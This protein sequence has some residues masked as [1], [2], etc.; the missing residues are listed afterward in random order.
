MP[1][2]Q[3]LSKPPNFCHLG[4][5]F[6]PARREI[7]LNASPWAQTNGYFCG[8]SEHVFI[9]ASLHGMLNVFLCRAGL[10]LAHRKICLQNTVFN[11]ELQSL[12]TE[13]ML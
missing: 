9:L 8:T 11:S 1:C 10:S 3:K 6:A 5:Y 12:G 4:D 7:F 2:K 13:D